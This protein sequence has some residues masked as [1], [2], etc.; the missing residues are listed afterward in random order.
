MVVG[1]PNGTDLL[2]H[3]KKRSQAGPR[4]TRSRGVDTQDA[5]IY[6]VIMGG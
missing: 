3:A 5:G 6:A 2:A 1:D 4:L